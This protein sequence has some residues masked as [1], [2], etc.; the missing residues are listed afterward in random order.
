MADYEQIMKALRNAHAAGDT[1][2]AQRLAK[3]A[4]EARSAAAVPV[5]PEAT[6]APPHAPEQSGEPELSWLGRQIK[7]VGEPINAANRAFTNMF[8][9]GGLD[10]IEGGIDALLFD[11][12]F[13]EARKASRARSEQQAQDYPWITGAAGVAGAVAS[14]VAKLAAARFPMAGGLGARIKAGAAMGAALGGAQGFMEGE[15]GIESRVRNALGGATMGA[16]FGAAIPAA[17]EGAG[18]AYRGARNALAERRA[19]NE[20]AAHLGVDRGTARVVAD[21]VAMTDPALA[22]QALAH[23]DAMLADAGPSVRG[24]LD[25]AIQSPGE[26]ARI[27][28]GRIEDRAAQAGAGLV[29][30]MDKALGKPVGLNAAQ[31]AIRQQTQPAR[32]AAYEA[33]YSRPIGYAS[34]EGDQLRKLLPRIP[35]PALR[36]ANLLMKMDGDKS[37][38]IL[39]SI[40]DDGAATIERLPDVRQWDYIKRALENSARV[41]DGKG[42]LGGQTP[43]GRA[44]KSL[45]EEVRDTLAAAVP[46]YRVALD[47]A[48]DAIGRVQGVKFGATMLRPGTTREEVADFLKGK[49]KPEIAA[50]KQG[51]RQQIDDTLANVRAVATDHNIDARQ[52]Y[53]AMTDLSSPSAQA[54]MEMLLGDDWPEM[55]A[56]LEAAQ[57]ALGLRAGVAANSRTFGRGEANNAIDAAIE[58]GPIANAEPIGTAKYAWRFLN[59]A[60]PRQVQGAKAKVKS[61]IADVLTRPG[62]AQILDAV[63]AARTSGQALPTLGRATTNAL[64][65]FGVR[66]LPAGLSEWRNLLLQQ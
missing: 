54:K 20:L 2:A 22:R 55:K 64:A 31:G 48:S 40:A 1:A 66:S 11:R 26:G 43:M 10:E 7:A 35:G 21:H 59:Q 56:R 12:K 46:E 39:F 16:L 47:T 63:E 53:K 28:L 51:V 38:E 52:A 9:L 58:K 41:E 8:T 29:E 60:T 25:V 50:I 13:S 62:A 5:A 3:M 44:Y 24:A 30:Q 4:Q 23:G 57:R 33:A 15:T 19:M 18:A 37:R 27:A 42:A 45:A 61:Q 14:P 17:A 36:D 32:Q 6:G 49:T 65:G 34:D